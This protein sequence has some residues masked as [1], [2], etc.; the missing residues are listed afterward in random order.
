MPDYFYVNGAFINSTK[1]LPFCF[2]HLE[3]F[4]HY[5]GKKQVCTRS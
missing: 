4:P 1:S 2:V 5:Y 3:S